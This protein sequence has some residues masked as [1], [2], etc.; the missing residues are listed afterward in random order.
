ME[1]LGYTMVDQWSLPRTMHGSFHPE[2]FVPNFRG[3]SSAQLDLVRT[4]AE[5]N[6]EAEDG[7]EQRGPDRGPCF[8][9]RRPRSACDRLGA[10]SP[11]TASRSS[12]GWISPSPGKK[13]IRLQPVLP[14]V[15]VVV[16]AARAYRLS[17][18]PRSNR[19]ASTTRIWSARRIVE[20]RCAMT[21]VVRPLHQVAQTLLDHRS[22]SESSD[23]VASS[24]IKMRGSARIARAIESRCR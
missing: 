5:R 14:R 17:C 2:C 9:F 6:I 23:E 3:F 10:R 4:S 21:N 11:L 18:V 24:R 16:A 22:D 19:S 13:K 20:S 8:Q 1:D 15:E 7:A 12:S